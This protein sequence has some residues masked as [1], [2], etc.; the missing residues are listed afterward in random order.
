LVAWIHLIEGPVGAGKSTL[1]AQLTQ[2]HAAPR[3]IDERQ[4]T[5]TIATMAGS[6][7]L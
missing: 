1:A 2:R 6:L 3:L 4:A 7:I 5:K